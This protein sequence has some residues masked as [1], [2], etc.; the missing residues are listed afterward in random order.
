MPRRFLSRLLTVTALGLWS[1]LASAQPT[2]SEKARVAEMAGAINELMTSLE[3]RAEDYPAF[4]D[5]LEQGL[6]S[7][8]EADATVAELIENLSNATAQMEDGSEFDTAIDD[9][10][11]QTTELIAEAEASN[12]SIIKAEVP[13]LQAVLEGLEEDDEARARTVIEARNLIRTLEENREAIAF[14]IK[15]DSV[16]RAAELIR[17]NVVD[18]SE[19]IDSGK[20]VA[21]NLLDE[22]SP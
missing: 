18:F 13:N 16:Q 6:V 12:N 4:L 20:M 19:I 5:Q 2:P 3:Q 15:A 9:Y 1:G 8:D 17:A 14:F 11:T 22:T 21:S 10:K 7:I